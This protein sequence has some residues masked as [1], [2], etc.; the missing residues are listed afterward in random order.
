MEY[1]IK[2]IQA[3]PGMWAAHAR[4]GNLL[5]A[6]YFDAERSL[7]HFKKAL[8]AINVEQLEEAE[9]TQHERDE[10]LPKMDLPHLKFVT[11]HVCYYRILLVT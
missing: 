2:A 10:F 1:Y 11:L 9:N 8:H 3:D 6:V 5:Q 7:E 4:L